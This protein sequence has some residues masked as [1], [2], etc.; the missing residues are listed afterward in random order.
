[1]PL[2]R[3]QNPLNLLFK[4]WMFLICIWICFKYT[5]SQMFIDY[6][7]D[8]LKYP[9]PCKCMNSFKLKAVLIAIKITIFDISICRIA[10]RVYY[11]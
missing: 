7:T 2:T 1:M 3:V 4:C 10:A 8:F 11:I 5:C 9:S 6:N